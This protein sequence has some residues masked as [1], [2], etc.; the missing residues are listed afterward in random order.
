MEQ[1]ETNLEQIIKVL[2]NIETQNLAEDV[3][4]IKWLSNITH[5]DFKLVDSLINLFLDN[6]LDLTLSKNLLRVLR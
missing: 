2:E 6:I 3:E 1:D 5:P 4:I